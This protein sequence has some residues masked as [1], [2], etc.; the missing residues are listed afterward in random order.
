MVFKNDTYSIMNEHY[1]ETNVLTG[2]V[3]N[4]NEPGFNI[5]IGK[6]VK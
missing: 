6:R 2:T 5:D 1:T 4:V 3:I